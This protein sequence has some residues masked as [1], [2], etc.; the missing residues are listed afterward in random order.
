MAQKRQCKL[1]GMVLWSWN[2]SVPR[3]T[4]GYFHFYYGEAIMPRADYFGLNVSLVRTG[5]S[6]CCMNTCWTFA[7]RCTRK[8]TFFKMLTA[9][10]WAAHVW[11][12]C[13]ELYK[14][15]VSLFSPTWVR[16]DTNAS[17][18]RI[19][20]ALQHRA[21]LNH[22]IKHDSVCK[23]PRKSKVTWINNRYGGCF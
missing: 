2:V 16:V 12:S 15:H 4:Q 7:L 10:F 9:H 14:P 11:F 22:A 20:L 3:Q 18:C 13:L 17:F 8:I 1:Y 5:A 23:C 21:L 6:M 19:C